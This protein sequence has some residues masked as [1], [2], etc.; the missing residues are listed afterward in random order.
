MTLQS[1][2]NKGEYSKLP[3]AEDKSPKAVISELIIDIVANASRVVS[4]YNLDSQ[5]IHT[6]DKNFMELVEGL[7]C[8]IGLTEHF[9]QGEENKTDFEGIK[10]IVY[11]M[12]D[13]LK[14]PV[15]L[16]EL[17]TSLTG[18]L[19]VTGLYELGE[20]SKVG[21]IEEDLLEGENGRT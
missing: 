16:D 5:N 3:E 14:K 15:V 18:I 9:I 4:V 2:E 1:R 13:E 19:R 12:P 8:L 20:P 11:Q 7:R 6:V 10:S 17:V 21:I